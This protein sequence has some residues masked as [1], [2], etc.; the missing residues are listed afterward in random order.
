M[1]VLLVANPTA[2]SGK[3]QVRIEKALARMA[4]RGWHPE[5][6]ATEPEGRTVGLVRD[7]IA[8][9]DYGA[10]IYMGGDGTFR[11]V[12]KGILTAGGAHPMGMLPSGTANDQGK[13]FGVSNKPSALDDNLRII[14]EGNILELDV[15]EIQ[16]LDDTGEVTHEDRFFDSCGWGL[17]AEILHGRNRDRQTV[18]KIPLLREIYRDQA[19]YAGAALSKTLQSYLEPIKFSARVVAD[20]GVHEYEGLTDLIVNATPIYAGSWVPSPDSRPDDGFFELVPMVGRRDT[21]SKLVRDFKAIPIKQRHLD[22]LGVRLAQGFSA[23]RFEI[24]MERPNKPEVRSQFDGE[25]WI[26]GRHYRVR[27]LKR[28]LKL[29]VPRWWEPP[30]AATKGSGSPL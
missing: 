25:E 10:V 2:Q 4:D 30:W 27:V 28:Q 20:G 11:E 24:E 19:V 15:G 22:M 3:A 5:F 9:Q 1:R 7:H 18:E 23:Q 21:L 29:I 12:A 17:Q 6:L 16:R 13:S 26:G 8:G 14:E